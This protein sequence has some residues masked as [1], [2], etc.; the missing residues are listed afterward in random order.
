MTPGMT[1]DRRVPVVVLLAQGGA[2]LAVSGSVEVARWT[3]GFFCIVDLAIAIAGRTPDLAGRAGHPADPLIANPARL[4]VLALSVAVSAAVAPSLTGALRPA[5]TM[6]AVG[7]L[8]AA[9]LVGVL[10]GRWAP[11]AVHVWAG[12]EPNRSTRHELIPSWLLA[13]SIR[14]D[15]SDKVL[16]Y[17]APR[18]LVAAGL[19]LP[20]MI[21]ASLSLAGTGAAVGAL[22]LWRHRGAE[23]SMQQPPPAGRDRLRPKQ[24]TTCRSTSPHSR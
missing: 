2:L 8:V 7:N 19:L 5:V 21:S 20:A 18:A 10:P 14:L 4:L 9:V 17:A 22:L 23:P 1:Y 15:R 6:M 16:R 24:E 11:E 3:F 12:P 13:P